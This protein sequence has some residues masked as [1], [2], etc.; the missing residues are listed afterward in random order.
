MSR[1]PGL[2]QAH[3]LLC[4]NF[5]MWSIRMRASNKGRHISGA[6]ALTVTPP[7]YEEGEI[8][9]LSEEFIKRALS[10]SKGRPSE[11]VLTIEKISQKPLLVPLLKPRTLE[12]RSPEEARDIIKELLLKSGVK[13]LAISKALKVIYSE[14]NMRG[15]SLME[16]FR[17]ER[18]EPDKSRGI[19]V[20]RLGI[21]P[22]SEEKFSKMLSA[23]GINI[24][25]VREAIILA[26]K[27]ASCP[28]IIAEVCI[29]DDPDYTTGY[30][31]SKRLGYLRIPNIKRKGSP[32]GGR[33]FFV[34]GKSIKKIIE[35]LEK[36]PVLIRC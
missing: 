5:T 34:K 32:A 1:W 13:P 35:Y 12:C 15:A 23:L 27:V 24:L 21:D 29:S 19:R 10:H 33:V 17:G 3:L 26:S 8:L 6:E 28:G 7:P 11:I 22:A 20:S 31:A 9:R 14:K 16:P 25:R 18:L 2:F 30:V 4:Y 36:K